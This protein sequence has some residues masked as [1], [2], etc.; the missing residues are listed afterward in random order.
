MCFEFTEAEELIFEKRYKEA[1][2]L[3]DTRYN[4]WLQQEKGLPPIGVQ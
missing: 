2:I 3:C 1:Y 4:A